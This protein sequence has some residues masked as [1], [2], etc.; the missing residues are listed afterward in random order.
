[1]TD[2]RELIPFVAEHWKFD[3]EKYPDLSGVEDPILIQGFI[4]RHIAL[5]M[6]KATGALGSLGERI[7]H[8]E[9]SDEKELRLYIR[10][11]FVNTLRL[12][13]VAGMSASDLVDE[14]TAWA[15]EQK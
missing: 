7:D 6:A 14:V 2:L 1:V 15:M 4:I 13:E 11:F 3:G 5:H 10:K 12:A 9:L 8:G